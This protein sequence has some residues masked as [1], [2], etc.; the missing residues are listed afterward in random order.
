M[1][2]ILE[3]FDFTGSVK[4]LNNSNKDYIIYEQ[5]VQDKVFI[6]IENGLYRFSFCQGRYQVTTKKLISYDFFLNEYNKYIID[7]YQHLYDNCNVKITS[8]FIRD[9]IDNEKS[10]QFKY[11]F[12]Y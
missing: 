7:G 3:S 5:I 8:K 1:E 4:L 12:I 11:Q 9:I 2:L 10:C 6:P